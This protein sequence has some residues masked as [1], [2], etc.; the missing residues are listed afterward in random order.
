MNIWRL[1][2]W[3]E[4]EVLEEEAEAVPLAE[5][6]EAEDA[7]VVLVADFHLVVVE[8][9]PAVALEVYLEEAEVEVAEV[10]LEGLAVGV[11]SV[12]TEVQVQALVQE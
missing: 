10:L 2:H 9:H 8:A 5:A 3:V 12:A 11:Y 1:F 6:E 4:A 7:A